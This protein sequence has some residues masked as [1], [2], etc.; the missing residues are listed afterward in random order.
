MK[1]YTLILPFIF[2][3]TGLTTDQSS[4][5]VVLRGVLEVEEK[6]REILNHLR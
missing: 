3:S 5:E 2:I 4:K 1:H 6:E